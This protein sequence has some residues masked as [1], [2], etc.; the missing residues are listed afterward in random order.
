MNAHHTGRRAASEARRA[1]LG[2]GA[3]LA[4]AGL[5]GATDG[6]N[7]GSLLLYAEFDNREGVI[8]V[9]AVTNVE[10]DEEAADVL[11]EFR[12][13]GRY[14]DEGQDINCEEFNRTETLT[15]ADN[16]TAI[17]N[18]HNPQHEQGYVYLYAKNALNQ[19]IVHNF[20]TGNLMT[21]D[22]LTTFDYSV[23]PVSYRG[24]GNGTLTDLDGDE[25]LDMDGC[26]Y[27]PNPD[28]ILIPRFLGQ[29][30]LFNSELILI[31]LSGGTAFDTRIDFLIW[32]DNEEIFSSEHTIHCW[33]RVS[34]LDISGIFA[35]SFLQQW[36]N[37]DPQEILGAPAIESGW[38]RLQ[39]G[40]A[41]SVTTSIDDPSIY[42]VL[43]ER[44]GARGAADLPFEEGARTNGELLPR[45][46]QGDIVDP[47]C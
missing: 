37:H 40:V 3:T 12:Y 19:P 6:R 34:L 14:D 30:G 41:N 10:V 26:E 32:N 7:A 17:T 23:N 27:T 21:V 44:L 9:L 29:G 20:L 5:A 11:V 33:E 1:V 8:T 36:T 28:A 31:A 47:D 4:L 16:F 24:I 45:T 39:G 43:V 46:V 35:N 18:F 42:A 15:P 38:M 13:I 25:H 2:L 22:G